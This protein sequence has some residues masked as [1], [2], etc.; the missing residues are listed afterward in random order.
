MTVTPQ[1]ST[2]D[3]IELMRR[4]RMSCLPVVVGDH[5]VGIVTET[6]FMAIAGQLLEQKLR[7]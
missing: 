5:L 3:A 7:E 6:H 2:L 4:H 1:T